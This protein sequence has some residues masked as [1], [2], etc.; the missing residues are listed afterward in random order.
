MQR[1]TTVCLVLALAGL[2]VSP[3]VARD[4]SLDDLVG[5][6]CG[7]SSD[8]TFSKTQLSVV[9]HS[10][11]K[12]KHG[13]VLKVAGADGK[14]RRIAVRWKPEKPGNST[15][16]ELSANRRQLEQLP[17]SEGDKSPRRVFRRC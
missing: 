6:W 8:Y 7:E 5:R 12:P 11:Q 16:F 4:V 2:F 17:Q 3:A 15:E 1:S 10:G 9:L 13:P 14:E